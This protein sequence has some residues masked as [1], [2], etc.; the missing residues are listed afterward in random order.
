MF[1]RYFWILWKWRT[2]NTYFEYFIASETRSISMLTVLK[3][4][5]WQNARTLPALCFI[6]PCPGARIV[7]YIVRTIY[8]C[9][10]LCLFL[11]FKPKP[12]FQHP[13]PTR[14]NLYR[15]LC[16][17]P[18]I[19]T[20]FY[21]CILTL[22]LCSQFPLLSVVVHIL[23]VMNPYCEGSFWTWNIF[24]W[25]WLL[26]PTCCPWQFV[27]LIPFHTIVYSSP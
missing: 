4:A 21:P 17:K 22:Q 16:L 7:P 26:N 9:E 20:K 24:L 14:W 18:L 6:S 23:W 11:H 15:H 27:S 3:M 8:H 10:V 5:I 12:K 25:N 19:S 2:K 13:L 1:R